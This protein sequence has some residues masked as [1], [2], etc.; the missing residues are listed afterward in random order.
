MI[1]FIAS[2]KNFTEGH[3]KRLEWVERIGDQVDLYGR[4]FNEIGTKEEGLCD[5]MF[6][7]VVENGFYKCSVTG[8]VQK[9][10]IEQMEKI[11]QGNKKWDSY[12]QLVA[13]KTKYASRILIGYEDINN[14]TKYTIYIKWA[15]LEHT[16]RV[17]NILEKYYT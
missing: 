11:I 2:N 16:E 13:S 15:C 14:P 5:Y 9:Y 6:S 10:S 8:G 4:G 7:V 1:S 12:F 3:K 17:L